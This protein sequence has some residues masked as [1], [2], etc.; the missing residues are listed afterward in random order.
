MLAIQLARPRPSCSGDEIS[1]AVALWESNHR[2]YIYYIY[3]IYIY[4]GAQ[5]NIYDTEINH[6]IIIM[7]KFHNT[8]IFIYYK[9][10]KFHDVAVYYVK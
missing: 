6:S 2:I 8:Y 9:K 3:I 4:S 7:W 10:K 5:M 1:K